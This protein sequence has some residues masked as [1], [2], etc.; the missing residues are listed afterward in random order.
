MNRAL[1]GALLAV[2][3]VS[4]CGGSR[5]AHSEIRRQIQD[6]GNSTLIP[7]AIAIRRVVSESSNRAIAET[8]VE[9]AF[10]FERDTPTSPWYVSSVRL[11]DQNWVPV[12]ELLA[13]LKENRSRAT[14]ESLKKLAEG[15]EAYRV[16]N[17]TAPDASTI[18][19]LTDVLHPMYMKDLIREDAWGRPI[20][21]DAAGG[22]FRFRSFGADGQR[23]TADDVA[24]PE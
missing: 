22:K 3:L 20:E 7:E 21:V 8:T 11:G 15:V 16:K 5:L 18:V 14:A 17:G 19:A 4:G 6:L 24:L 10:Q 13:A 9:L 1:H 2:L 12:Q 23:G